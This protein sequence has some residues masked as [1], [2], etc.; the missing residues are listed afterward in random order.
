MIRRMKM[1][2]D[3]SA[4]VTKHDMTRSTVRPRTTGQSWGD[5][6]PNI[7]SVTVGSSN[8]TSLAQA[9]LEQTQ[10][11]LAE[12][13][14]GQAVDVGGE[15]SLGESEPEPLVDDRPRHSLNRVEHEEVA[16][17]TPE[18]DKHQQAT[19]VT[20][21]QFIVAGDLQGSSEGLAFEQGAHFNYGP[22]VE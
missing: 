11:G 1:A 17:G 10:V 13:T 14:V 3:L 15:A 21:H 19:E 18:S 12:A 22:D 9:V 5:L 4:H 2:W 20:L 16:Q 8:N 6:D 7:V